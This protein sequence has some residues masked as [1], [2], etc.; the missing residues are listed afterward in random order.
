MNEVAT[1]VFVKGEKALYAPKGEPAIIDVPPMRF[2]M[3]DGVGDPNEPAGAY[4]QAVSLLYALSYTVKMSAK[5]GN[6]P[7]GYF[8]Y[9]VAPLEGFW[10]MADGSEGVD[11]DRK[12]AFAWTAMIRQPDF[13][14][15]DVLHW[16]QAEV[17]RKKKLDAGIAR[18][19]PYAEGLCVHCLHT[20]PYSAEPATLAR[21]EA[22]IRANGFTADIPARRH[23][24]VYLQDPQRTDPQ[25][26]KTILRTPVRQLAV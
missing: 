24:E 20:G 17:R 13:V 14:T 19:A 5:S 21:M 12:S 16:A 18:L 8:G 26:L 6:A 2:F 3:V 23:H 4:A 25:K 1:S 22:F 15:E 10:R 7:Q 11:Y 9:G